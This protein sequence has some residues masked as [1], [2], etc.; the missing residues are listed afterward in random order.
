MITNATKILMGALEE[1]NELVSE[2]KEICWFND[3][4]DNIDINNEKEVMD[5]YAELVNKIIIEKMKKRGNN[6]M[7]RAAIFVRG[8]NTETQMEL[9]E[10]YAKENGYEVKFTTDKLQNTFERSVEYDVLI[11]AG[12]T[13][14]NRN[15]KNY[16]E[17]IN[18]FDELGINVLIAE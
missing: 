5:A 7:K 18:F 11:T 2:E 9:C 10:R 17:I 15:K 12:V 16:D 8:N 13:R 3:I 6:R 14:I 1:Y 4:L